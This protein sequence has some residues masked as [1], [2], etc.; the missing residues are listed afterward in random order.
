MR[1]KAPPGSLLKRKLRVPFIANWREYR[2]LSQEQLAARVEDLLGTSFSTSTL[3]RIENAKSPYNQR[4][5]EALSVALECSTADLLIRDPLRPDAIWS[6]YDNLRKAT[7][8]QRERIQR[9]TDALL[10]DD[11]PAPKRKTKGD[12]AA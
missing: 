12:E 7:P 4:Q 10:A 11:E 3:S 9:V 1:K 2:T 6:I 5:L 8:A